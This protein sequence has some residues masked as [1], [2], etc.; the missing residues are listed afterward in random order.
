M[1]EKGCSEGEEKKGEV[2]ERTKE[3]GEKRR[4]SEKK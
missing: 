4:E 1:I 2:K 3:K